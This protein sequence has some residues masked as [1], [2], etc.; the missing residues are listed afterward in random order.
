MAAKESKIA[1]DARN[2]LGAEE[3]RL[4]EFAERAEAAVRERADELRRK[5]RD[6]YDEAYDQFDTAQRYLTERVQ[7]RPVASTLAAVGVGVL[8]G[9]LLVGGRRR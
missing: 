7:E 9:M 3:R 4:K 8:I 2:G 1:E 6:Y 5:A